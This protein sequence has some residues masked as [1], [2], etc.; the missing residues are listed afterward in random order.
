MG[1]RAV[2]NRDLVAVSVSQLI[3]WG[4]IY[5]AL[6]LIATELLKGKA[7]PWIVAAFVVS[8]VSS[9]WVGELIFRRGA[10]PVLTMGHFAAGLAFAILSLAPELNLLYFI[11]MGMAMGMALYDTAFAF[12]AERLEGGWSK[13]VVWLTIIGGF[14]SSVFWPATSALLS[15]PGL[16]TLGAVYAVLNF[17]CA[18]GLP[19]AASRRLDR[20]PADPSRK[21]HKTVLPLNLTFGLF[22]FVLNA[23]SLFLIPILLAMGLPLPA[24]LGAASWMGVARAASRLSLLGEGHLRLRGKWLAFTALLML[25]VALLGASGSFWAGLGFSLI[26]GLTGGVFSVLRGETVASLSGPQEY[27]LLQGKTSTGMWM[28]RALTPLIILPLAEAQE[29]TSL[30][31]VLAVAV[32]VGAVPLWFAV[33]KE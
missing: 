10:L 8:G 1:E 23:G 13:S 7:T 6:P 32:G 12:L 4:T 33:A 18:V 30:A 28:A 15:V 14:A 27:A 29:N 21:P 20:A 22:Q 26:V 19:W 25:G 9:P 2:F 24:A 17:A 11:P 31:G 5:Y 3:S 16:A